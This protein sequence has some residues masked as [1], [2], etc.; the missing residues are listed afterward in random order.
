M[1]LLTFILAVVLPLNGTWEF[2]QKGTAD[3][4]P[5]EVPGAVQLDLMRLDLLPDPFIGRNERLV[6]WVGEKDWQY[7]RRFAVDA[8]LLS[9]T[10]QELV[11]E[12][13][14]TYADVYL[15]GQLVQ[16]CDNMFRTWRIPVA[17][18]L[19]EGDN[20]LFV[21]FSSVFK[22]DVPKYLAAPYKLQAWPNNDQSDI[23]ISLY[24]RKA[25]YTYGWDWGPRIITA[26][27]WKNVSM[28][29]GPRMPDVQVKTLS[30]SP[31]RAGMQAVLD[32]DA[33]A[34]IT[35]VA[36]GRTL[37]RAHHAAGRAVCDFVVKQPRLWWSNGL[38]DPALYDFDITVTSAEGTVSRRIATGIRTV[39]VDRTDG[40]MT[41]V[42]NGI[43]VFCKGA[44]WI[45]ADNFPTRVTPERCRSLVHAASAANMNMLR[46]WGGGLY[47]LDD[48]Y[49]ACD[50]EGI[51][52]WQDMTFACGMFPADE[53]YLESVAAEVRDNVR[54]LR[55]HPS[56]V[57]WCGNNE[58]EISYF[59]W[60]WNRTLLPSQRTAYEADLHKLFYETI[61]QAIAEE[62]DTRYYH[63]TSPS[64]GYNGIP[65]GQGDAH[66][67]SVW[68]GGMVDEYLR[69]ANIARFMSEYGFQSYACMPSIENFAAPED[70]HVGSSV[71]LAHQKAWHDETRDPN[72]GDNQIKKYMQAYYGW[73]PE[74]FETFVYLSQF[75]QAEA[76]KVAMEAHRRAKPWCM[77]TLFWQLNDCW[78]ASSW[79]SVDYEGRWKAL[80]HYAR[81]AY[82]EVLVSPYATEDGDVVVQ[83]VSDRIRPVQTTLRVEILRVDG[84]GGET[85][86][87]PISVP[88]N[89]SV[90]GWRG[91]VL[92]ENAFLYTEMME[93]G[94]VLSSNIWFPAVMSSLAPA[95]AKPVFRKN[96]RMLTISCD[97]LVRGLHLWTDSGD[98]APD[99]YLTI[100]PGH[101]VTLE[102]DIDMNTLH[103]MTLNDILP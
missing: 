66:F 20:E 34:E 67:W 30:V 6:Q 73:V 63:P 68:K 95:G 40:A 60:G 92:P 55:N 83:V 35:I 27:L 53:A 1:K 81:R 97:R 54:R 28:E 56:I 46:V 89:A 23:W 12:G 100:V 101:P 49:E 58:N 5:A 42:L 64:T 29:F 51:L 9:E 79:S 41:V 16:R 85:H 13:V 84:T 2:R 44:N 37:Y 57:L 48:F 4:L 90:E 39:E 103:Y 47:E 98:A 87:Y 77:G 19:R 31:K 8:D 61:P 96:G 71:M 24:A 50:R 93:N 15:N 25:G 43:P 45:P 74:S 14:D 22:V 7:R 32:L 102:W 78:P 17:G 70:R 82:S 21:D 33:D 26:G 59:E 11:L 91:K 36:E 10:R 94:K 72:F 75:Q 18:L 99:D 38:G 88:S 80:H 69:P 86:E 62:D 65:Y 3:W 52:V 76:V